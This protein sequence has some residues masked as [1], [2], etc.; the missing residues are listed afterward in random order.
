MGLYRLYGDGHG[1]I[2]WMQAYPDNPI[3]CTASACQ[4]KKGSSKVQ[5]K[6]AQCACPQG[7]CPDIAAAYIDQI[8]GKEITADCDEASGNCNISIQDFPIQLQTPCKSGDCVSE[9]NPTL[10]SGELGSIHAWKPPKHVTFQLLLTTRRQR[11]HNLESQRGL[12]SEQALR[13]QA[14]NG[15]RSTAR[16]RLLR[17]SALRCGSLLIERGNGSG[18]QRKRS[19]R[20]RNV[21]HARRH[22]LKDSASRLLRSHCGYPHHGTAGAVRHGSTR[23]ALRDRLPQGSQQRRI[24]HV[25]AHRQGARVLRPGKPHPRSQVSAWTALFRQH[26]TQLKV[27]SMLETYHTL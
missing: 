20:S 4:F 13:S 12:P 21:W 16:H 14:Q 10:N 18:A 27:V 11:A 9:K 17:K 1:V 24:G 26:S 6:T 25:C 19:S 22:V 3:Q 15:G 8:Q 5:C 23:H 7:A 2:F